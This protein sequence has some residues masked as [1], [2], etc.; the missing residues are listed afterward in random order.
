MDDWQELAGS[1]PVENHWDFTQAA[2]TRHTE[3]NY[4]PGDAP[5]VCREP[6]GPRP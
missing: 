1:L 2:D 6:A 5:A 3:G 4:H